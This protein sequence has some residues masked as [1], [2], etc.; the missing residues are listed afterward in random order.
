MY[1]SLIV[2]LFLASYTIKPP[3][4]VYIASLRYPLS[5]AV[6]IEKMGKARPLQKEVE[7]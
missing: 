2:V 5:G 3:V 6:A 4:M 7:M 1:S